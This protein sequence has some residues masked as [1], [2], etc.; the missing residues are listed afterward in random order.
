MALPVVGRALYQNH[1][2]IGL[3]P[4]GEQ[5]SYKTFLPMLDNHLPT[6]PMVVQNVIS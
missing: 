5:I 3:I 1:M 4:I 2:A 6:H